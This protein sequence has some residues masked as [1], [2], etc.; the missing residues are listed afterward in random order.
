MGLSRVGGGSARE[1]GSLGLGGGVVD[2]VGTWAL[3]LG[4]LGLG[5]SRSSGAQHDSRLTAN[6][7]IRFPILG[8]RTS[9]PTTEHRIARKKNELIIENRYFRLVRLDFSVSAKKCPHQH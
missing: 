9:A 4:E 6:S 5:R 1:R 2:G 8:N 7:V 3:G